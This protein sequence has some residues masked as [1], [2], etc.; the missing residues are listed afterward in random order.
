MHGAL[1]DATITRRIAELGDAPLSLSPADFTKL[2]AAEYDKWAGVIRVAGV[3]A[4]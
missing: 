4:E 2:V 3:R 1:A